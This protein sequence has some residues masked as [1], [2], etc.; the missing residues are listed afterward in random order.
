MRRFFTLSV[1]LILLLLPLFA[2]SSIDTSPKRIT[3]IKKGTDESGEYYVRIL[4]VDELSAD[5]GTEVEVEAEARG[6]WYPAFYWNVY[7]NIYGTVSIE[8]QFGPMYLNGTPSTD[9]EKRIDY[10]VRLEHIRT[11][12]GNMYIN[13][14]PSAGSITFK[15]HEFYYSD[16]CTITNPD[17]QTKIETNT[18]SVPV[19]YTLGGTVSP[20]YTGTVCDLWNRYGCAYVKLDIDADNPGKPDGKYSSVVTVVY[21]TD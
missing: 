7:G 12:I 11:R 14:T 1:L 15:G 20:A 5:F 21:I 10:Y 17:S 6:N 2:D 3:A 13:E 8:F 18:V 4:N 19:S 9:E 16:V